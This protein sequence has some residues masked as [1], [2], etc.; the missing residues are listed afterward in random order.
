MIIWIA[1]AAGGLILGVVLGLVLPR[2]KLT[3]GKKKLTNE[4]LKASYDELVKED[5]YHIFDQ[6]FH[7]ELTEKAKAVFQ[8]VIAQNTVVLTAQLETTTKIIQEHLDTEIS[9]KLQTAFGAYT[10]AVSQAQQDALTTIKAAVDASVA[11]QAQFSSQLEQSIETR[12]SEIMTGFQQNMAEI[13][14][15]YVLQ[16]IGEQ[17]SIKEQLPAILREMEAQQEAMQKDMRL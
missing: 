6:D 5:V 13:V 10:Q 16:A 17:A 2:L 8:D 15:H 7:K 11:Q 9:G 1:I 4:D 14:S 12:K 3:K